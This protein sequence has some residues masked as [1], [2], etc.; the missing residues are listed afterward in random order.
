MKK[1]NI[2]YIGL[3]VSIVFNLLFCLIYFSSRSS[4]SSS[5]NTKEINDSLSNPEFREKIANR[6]I[7]KIICSGLFYPDFYDPVGNSSIDSA[8]QNPLVDVNCLQAAEKILEL[9]R[10]LESVEHDYR[11]AEN[12]LKVFGSSG[13]F[14]DYK[15]L[16]D[17]A[18]SKLQNTKS[19]IDKYENIIKN[20]DNSKDGNF[21]G[22]AVIHRYRAKT[23]NGSV[24]FGNSLILLTPKM[25]GC[26]FT[27]AMDEQGTQ[28]T[29]DQ[30]VIRQLLNLDY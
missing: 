27:F 9:K 10:T 14:Y 15:R 29:A 20:R 1:E 16:R 24:N 22:W 12:I 6:T 18:Y 28:L 7:K 23:N 26:L 17:E 30:N 21:I 4:F 8:F 5:D 13:V 19:E 2:L 3:G 11:E 25:D